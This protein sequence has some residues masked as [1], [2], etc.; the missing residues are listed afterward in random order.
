MKRPV[1]LV[2]TMLLGGA[3]A[4]CNDTRQAQREAPPRPVLVAE[5][6]YAPR[7][8][9]EALSGVVKARIESDLGFRVG[10]RIEKRLVDAGAI[11][12]KGDALATLDATDLRLQSEQAEADLAAA[13]SALAQSEAEEKRVTA[14][15]RQGWAAGTDFDRITSL[16][17]QARAGVLKAERAVSLAHN[18]LD[19]TTLA[20]D[21]DGVVSATLAEPGQVVA[22]GAPVVRLA[23]TDAKEAAV[24]VPETLIDKAR[25]A[26]AQVE[27]WALK[28]LA[29][30]A[31]LRELA[32]NADP[33]TR[34]YA[35]RFALPDAPE[36]ARL[37]MSVTVTLSDDAAPVAR[38]PLGALFET[39]S[40]PSVWTVDR[41]SGA[42][43][44]APITLAGTDADY[45][46]VLSGVP[47]GASVVALGVHKLDA[48]QKVRIVQN[49]AGL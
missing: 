17:N 5:A 38:L 28:G 49:L 1:V 36:A 19:Y 40:G 44:T 7:E 29:L 37:G 26:K 30:P 32:P 33:A 13:R 12:H 11:V 9:S 21:A 22:A 23:H 46:Y 41:A 18:A 15:N 2:L 8:R 43:S 42:L 4:A 45:A 48:G 31:T 24:A 6:H 39:A 20:A 10:G 47:E 14:L 35:A 3:L 16:A 27:F 34:T 25:K